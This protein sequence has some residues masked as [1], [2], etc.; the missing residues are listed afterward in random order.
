MSHPDDRI[1]KDVQD[2]DG[3]E[4]WLG[5]SYMMPM[6]LLY[7]PPRCDRCG[8][9]LEIYN[10]DEGTQGYFCPRCDTPGGDHNA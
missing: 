10:A 8:R 2:L 4:W 1:I 3:I 7:T 6:P 9:E 5:E